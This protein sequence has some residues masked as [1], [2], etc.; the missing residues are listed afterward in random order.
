MPA[1]QPPTGSVSA[2][3]DSLLTKL[4]QVDPKVGRF[5]LAGL[6]ILACSALVISYGINFND[7]AFVA[8]YLLG[9]AL[10][11]TILVYITNNRIMRTAVC[12]I[13]ISAFDIWILGLF[14]SAFQIT[15]RLP[16]TACYLRLPVELPEVC[17]ERLSSDV[18]VIGALAPASAPGLSFG[19]GPEQVWL[20]QVDTTVT[21]TPAPA[22]AARVFVQFHDPVTRDQTIALGTAL[23]AAGWQ[24]EGAERGGE[25]VGNGTDR[26]EVR[27]FQTA[28]EAIAI[29]LG[30]AIH[31]LA[32]S[33]TVHV[34]DFARLGG[35]TPAGQLEIWL[36]DLG[37][38]AGG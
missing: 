35:Y 31:A 17:I 10:A 15:R 22:G 30:E 29:A 25:L 34:R 12:W 14:D 3:S 1:V 9:F 37:P 38:G 26:N 11:V 27:F 8:G 21:L 7:A 24:V 36:S 20:A 28:D 6:T 23:A 13:A 18:I 5:V 32:P 33:A 4:L 2:A 16:P 19:G